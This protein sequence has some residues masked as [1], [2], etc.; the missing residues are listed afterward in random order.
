[1]VKFIKRVV[2]FKTMTWLWAII[3]VHLTHWTYWLSKFP[4]LSIQ[5]RHFVVEIWVAVGNRLQ[6]GAGQEILVSEARYLSGLAIQVR[7]P[8]YLSP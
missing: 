2:K 8:T 5:R 1:L 6:S 4:G 3:K 7:Y